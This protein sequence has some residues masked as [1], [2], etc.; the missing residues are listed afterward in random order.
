MTAELHPEELA[1]ALEAAEADYVLIGGLAVGLHGYI[2]ATEDMDILIRA[3]AENRSRVADVL[4]ELVDDGD[5]AAKLDRWIAAGSH[6]VKVSTR[7]GRVHVLEEGEPPL[8]W[9]SV[10]ADAEIR[11]TSTGPVRVC[12]LTTLVALKQLAGRPRDKADLAELETTH[13]KL[14]EIELPDPG[15]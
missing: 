5:E 1:E 13:G 12:G 4:G 10:L 2:R 8:D 6:T 3:S 7:V 15:A 9:A 14:P 11:E